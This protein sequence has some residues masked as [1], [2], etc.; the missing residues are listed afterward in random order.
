MLHRPI[1]LLR[2]RGTLERCEEQVLSHEERGNVSKIIRIVRQRGT[3][4]GRLSDGEREQVCDCTPC[5]RERRAV[6]GARVGVEGCGFGGGVEAEE[7]A[8]HGLVGLVSFVST[9]M[10]DFLLRQ[11]F[12]YNQ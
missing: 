3:G 8:L 9:I 4:F 1:A 6:E 10:P 5:L 11:R 7:G 2:V 12:E